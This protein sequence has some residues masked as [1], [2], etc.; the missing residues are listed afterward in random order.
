MSL[1]RF[2]LIGLMLLPFVLAA[3]AIGGV[4]FLRQGGIAP[5]RIPHGTG[6]VIAT[7]AATVARGAYLARFGDCAACHTTRGGVP[8]AGGRGFTTA[9]GTLYSSNLTTDPRYGLG[10]WSADEFAHTMRNGVSRNGV[11]YPVFP[12]AH[13]AQ[14]DDSDLDALYAYLKTLPASAQA[15]PPNRLD[16]PASW[17][18]ALI[19]WRMLYHRAAESS[20]D[21]PSSSAPLSRGRYLVD[22]LGHCAQRAR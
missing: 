2:G 22:G 6:R 18:P 4:L 10:D 20:P 17:R 14:V 19:G 11:L 9:Y 21:L 13:F 15:P 3:I 12:Y 1:R 8:F 5:Y 16:F 7:D